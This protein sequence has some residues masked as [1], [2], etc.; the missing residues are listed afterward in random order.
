MAKKDHEAAFKQIMFDLQNRKFKPLYFLCGEEQ[1]YIDRIADYIENNALSDSE[2]DF[3]LTVLYGLE[4]SMTEIISAA[5]RFPM[6]SEYQVVIVKEAQNI[7]DNKVKDSSLAKKNDDITEWELLTFYLK[8]MAPQTILVFCYKHG[9]PDGRKKWVAEIKKAGVYFESDTLRD[10]EIGEWIKNYIGERKIEMDTRSVDLLAEYLGTDLSKIINELDK[11]LITLPAGSRR[12]T[13]EHIEKNI[14]ISKDFNVFELE[15]ALVAKNALKAHRITQYFADNQK[16]N[17]IQMI[18]PQLFNFFANI[19]FYHFMPATM[20]VGERDDFPTQRAKQAEIGK[21]LN[22]KAYPAAANL[23][24]AAKA[25]S[26]KKCMHI[27]ACLRQTDMA[28]KGFEFIQSTKDG[29]LYKEL[30]FKILH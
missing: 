27:L 26:A 10:Y 23:V 2:R 19:L 12:I 25:F 28:S 6:M 30:I 29:E 14:G 11:L 15:D 7:K 8:N 18:V 17:P 13:A 1:L 21:A 22:I 9:K 4:T 24:K 5:K 20:K 3:N 16:D